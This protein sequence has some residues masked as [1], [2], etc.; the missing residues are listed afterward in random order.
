[1]TENK[2]GYQLHFPTV[3]PKIGLFV[4]KMI[5]EKWPLQMN[6]ER[7]GYSFISYAMDATTN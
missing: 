6:F 3:T 5:S 1:M 7:I 2:I 4:T